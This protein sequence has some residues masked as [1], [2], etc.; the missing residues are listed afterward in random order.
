MR[1]NLFRLQEGHFQKVL[2]GSSQTTHLCKDKPVEE[3]AAD[4]IMAN[5]GLLGAG[6]HA[7]RPEETVHQDVELVHIF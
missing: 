2:M 1:P 4:I 7:Q 3:N 5:G 6:C